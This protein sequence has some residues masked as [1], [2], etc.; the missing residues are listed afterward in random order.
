MC[1]QG[2]T[3]PTGATGR[4]GTGCWDLQCDGECTID[5]SNPER[6][7]DKNGDGSCTVADC[8]GAEGATGPTGAQGP[9]GDRKRVVE[10]GAAEARGAQVPKE[11]KGTVGQMGAMRPVGDQ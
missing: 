10:G 4:Q 6:N 8:T 1:A 9:Q 2:P 3:G 5:L 7:E 11:E